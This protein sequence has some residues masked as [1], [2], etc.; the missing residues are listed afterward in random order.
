MEEYDSLNSLC[1]NEFEAGQRE[2]LTAFAE[3]TDVLI[4][5]GMF[6]EKEL[7]DRQK[8]NL[9]NK[10]KK[11]QTYPINVK[12]VNNP[13]KER[14]I[15]IGDAA[16]T[17]HPLAGQGFNLSIEDCY[18]MLDCLKS[19]KF[20]GKD[21]GALSVLKAYNNMRKTRKNYITLSTTIIFYLF[22][23]KNNHLNNAD[24]L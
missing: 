12:F 19:A 17:I 23:K 8:V 18:D 6:T 2:T 24:K 4:W 15:L 13:F 11:I 16:H 10:F 20:V 3:N 22:S 14:I 1:D 9:E 21:F 7:E 5:D